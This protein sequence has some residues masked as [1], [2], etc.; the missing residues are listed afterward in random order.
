MSS[1]TASSVVDWGDVEGWVS[2]L[3]NNARSRLQEALRHAENAVRHK[4]STARWE[5]LV[6]TVR[7]GVAS[8]APD[9]EAVAVVF[10]TTEWDE[11]FFVGSPGF[12]LFA[13]GSTEDMEVDGV[14]EFSRIEIG[15][16]GRKF[17]LSVDLCTGAIDQCQSI[18]VLYDRHGYPFPGRR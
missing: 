15:V 3:D 1:D 13:D 16:V 18:E 8:W 5:S 14:D 12:V 9:D 7:A 4:E 11:G 10:A 6:D 2:R 17:G